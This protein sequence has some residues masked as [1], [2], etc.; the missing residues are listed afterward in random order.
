MNTIANPPSELEEGLTRGSDDNRVLI[1]NVKPHCC[2]PGLVCHPRSIQV[3]VEIC[4]IKEKERKRRKRKGREEEEEKKKKRGGGGGGGE[5]K[6]EKER[7]E[8]TTA[9][10]LAEGAN[11]QGTPLGAIIKASKSII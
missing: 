1:I 4:P 2:E 11:V 8:D 7:N 6:R 3:C 9:K 10:H 5:R